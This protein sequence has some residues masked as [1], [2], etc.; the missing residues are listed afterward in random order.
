MF[1]V[2]AV[3]LAVAWI[4]AFGVLHVSAVAIH[5]LLGL[6]ILSALVHTIRPRRYR[7]GRE[8]LPPD[9]VR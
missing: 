2:L 9:A 5:A 4:L 6:A 7:G 8:A 3:L 1:M